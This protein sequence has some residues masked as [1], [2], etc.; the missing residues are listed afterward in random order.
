MRNDECR[1]PNDEG[2]TNVPVAMKMPVFLN[3]ANRR[4]GLSYLG[5]Y[6]WEGK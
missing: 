2:M 1:N 5:S 6:V 3:D 4:L